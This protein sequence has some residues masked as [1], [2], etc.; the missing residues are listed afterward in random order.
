VSLSHYSNVSFTFL[1]I[2]CKVLNGM[3]LGDGGSVE[4]EQSWWWI[5]L[6][7]LFG[8]GVG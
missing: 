6:D 2:G 8:G 3:G 7:L 5:N 4:K 1:Q